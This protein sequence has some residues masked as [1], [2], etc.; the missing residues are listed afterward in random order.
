MLNRKLILTGLGALALGIFG[1]AL[2]EWLFRPSLSFA[3]EAVLNLGTLGFTS[4]R[5]S[6]YEEMA[7][8]HSER[9]GLTLV[10]VLGV[11]FFSVA[12]L[13]AILF[14]ALY[15]KRVEVQRRPGKLA[16]ALHRGARRYA[17]VFF[18]L[19]ILDGVMIFLLTTRTGFIVRGAQDFEQATRVIAPYVSAQELLTL[20]SRF[21]QMSKESDH[22]QIVDDVRAIAVQHGLK[23]PRAL[24][25]EAKAG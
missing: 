18:F 10:S 20:R 23:L 2:W 25:V 3:S 11:I 13:T 1:N 12:V 21:A 14:R 7:K 6:I 17:N 9:T 4:L 16:L 24:S 22:D 15:V 8:D 19:L 5:D